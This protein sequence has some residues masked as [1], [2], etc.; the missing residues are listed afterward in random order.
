MPERIELS[1]EQRRHLLDPESLPSSV[2]VNN[3]T[4]TPEAWANKG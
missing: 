4:Y 1:E 3:K 2:K